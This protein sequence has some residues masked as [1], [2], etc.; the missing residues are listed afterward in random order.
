[1]RDRILA[2][3]TMLIVEGACCV[4]QRGLSAERRFETTISGMGSALEVRELD[5][6]RIRL[7]KDI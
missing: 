7:L 4:E 5:V 6:L 2:V 3:L 1:M